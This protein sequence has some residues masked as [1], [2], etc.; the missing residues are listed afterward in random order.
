VRV[1]CAPGESLMSPSS[2]GIVG[3]GSHA[4]KSSDGPMRALEEF[5]I[6]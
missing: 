4:P 1:R 6:F 2:R 5:P 3:A